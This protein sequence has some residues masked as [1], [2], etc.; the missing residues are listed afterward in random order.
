MRRPNSETAV[1]TRLATIACCALLAISGMPCMAAAEPVASVMAQVEAGEFAAAEVAIATALKQPGLAAA[2]GAALAFERERMRRIRRDFRH[3]EATIRKQLDERLGAYTEQEF[4]QWE[5]GGHIEMR[6]I[7]GE[8]R[9]FHRAVGNLFE[10]VPEV[11]ARRRETTALPTES[12]LYAAHALHAQWLA[13]AAAGAGPF[14]DPQRLRIT[15][16]ITVAADVVP[17]GEVLRAWIPYPRVIP[18][19]QQDIRFISSAPRGARIAPEST[20]QRTAYL[21]R[22][23]RRGQPTVFS[24]SYELTTRTQVRKLDPASTSDAVLPA[25]ALAQLGERPPHIVFTEALRNYSR[26]LVGDETRPYEIAKRLFRA[27]DQKPWA[28]A[29]EYSTIGNLSM[30]AHQAIHADCGEQ[31]MLLITLLRM[32]GIPARWQSGWQFSPTD[33]DSM[34]DWGMFYIAPYGWLPMDVTHGWL[35]SNDDAVAGF[36]LGNLDAYRVAFND[37]FSRDFVPVKQHVRSETI[38]SQRGEVEWSGGNLYFDTWD[39]DVRWKIVPATAQH[40]TLS[41]THRGTRR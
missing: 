33:F 20:L 31:T 30:H 13:Q 28:V 26:K 40:D 9:Y 15:H 16:T 10:I 36:Y 8:K 12:P 35:A 27:V 25:D 23:A 7:D 34:H 1:L 32:H 37:D 5:A 24:V 29:R 21:E 18:G 39:Y 14:V 2:S 19:Q 3:D 11:A 4:A 22:K 17:K 41:A 38:D 6:R